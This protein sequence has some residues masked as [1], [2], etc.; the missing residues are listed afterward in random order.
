M[1]RYVIANSAGEIIRTAMCTED[2]AGVQ[3]GV[4]EELVESDDA[5]PATH[6]I[7]GGAPVAYTAQ[8]LLL[9][10][11]RPDYATGW[12]NNT[13]KW[14]DP[15]SLADLRKAKAVEMKT[16]R[17][18]EQREGFV[19]SGNRFDSDPTSQMNLQ[20]AFVQALSAKSDGIPFNVDWTLANDTV[21]ALTRGQ[22]L[23]V[24]TT[25]QQHL[26]DAQTK[27]R[28]RKTAIAAA[29]NSAAVALIVW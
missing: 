9:K 7:V 23:A 29:S 28:A 2:S 1:K 25:L 10:S 3:A 21:V 24:G 17:D 27:Y 16:A 12:D 22:M 14:I 19:V 15:R 18:A 6:Y 20:M 26:T 5:Q 13:M 11:V 8:Q 4:R